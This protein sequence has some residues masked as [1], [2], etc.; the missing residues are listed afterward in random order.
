MH[1]SYKRW[2]LSYSAML[3]PV[4]SLLLIS[5]ASVRKFFL[6]VQSDNK[7]RTLF[8]ISAWWRKRVPGDSSILM[9]L[10]TYLAMLMRTTTYRTVALFF[11]VER[12]CGWALSRLQHPDFRGNISRVFTTRAHSVKFSFVS[13]SKL[14]AILIFMS[15]VWF[16]GSCEISGGVE[17]MFALIFLCV[18]WFHS[19]CQR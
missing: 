15:L 13:V 7:V 2:L 4:C 12:I 11:Y 18:T 19:S 1:F 9:S 14:T 17:A 16:G 5:T 8:N 6:S 10:D 3:F